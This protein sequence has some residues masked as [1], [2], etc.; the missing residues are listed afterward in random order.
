[1]RISPF[2]YNIAINHIARTFILFLVA[3]QHDASPASPF[4]VLFVELFLFC[5]IFASIT[6]I[7]LYL[8]TCCF[9]LDIMSSLT[10]LLVRFCICYQIVIISLRFSTQQLWRLQCRSNWPP[11][12]AV[13]RHQWSKTDQRDPKKSRWG[14]GNHPDPYFFSTRQVW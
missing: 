1:M 3:A 2:C 9:P 12:S 13:A 11:H 4:L 6:I 14:G 8:L 10:L 5:Y 7:L